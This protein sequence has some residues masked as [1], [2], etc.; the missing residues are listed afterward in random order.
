MIAS[1]AKFSYINNANGAIEMSEKKELTVSKGGAK[2]IITMA[3]I[4][5]GEGIGPNYAQLL[6]EII[7]AYPELESEI[8]SHIW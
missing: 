8:P 2:I 4:C 3:E 7:L 6:Q 1:T 5:H